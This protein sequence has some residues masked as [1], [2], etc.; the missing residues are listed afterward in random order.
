MYK[1][2]SQWRKYSVA[3]E[4]LP[5]EIS[6]GFML[7]HCINWKRTK[8]AKYW[9]AVIQQHNDDNGCWGLSL[10]FRKV[11]RRE[12]EK[13][14]LNCAS[15]CTS[16]LTV[17]RLSM[18]C[19]KPNTVAVKRHTIYADTSGSY[20]LQHWSQESHENILYILL[21][22]GRVLRPGFF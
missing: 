3:T 19:G 6:R 5:A 15:A 17:L 9:R 10:R 14:M 18:V 4:L 16:S 11:I 22:K 7:V 21:A 8:P 20:P 1:S 12:T 13:W 2:V